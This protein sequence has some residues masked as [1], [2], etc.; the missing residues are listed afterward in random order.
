MSDPIILCRSVRRRGA[1]SEAHGR[2]AL[3]YEARFLRRKRVAL[4]DGGAFHLDLPETTSLNPG[5]AFELSDGRLI[6]VDAADEP[7][8]AVA[9][10]LP[11]LAWHIGNRHAPC[12][13]EE[14]RLLIRRDHVLRDMLL[15][16]GAQVSEIFGPFA[17]EGGAYGHGRT[18]PHDHG[19][20]HADHA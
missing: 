13:I 18:L 16:L 19:H 11:R 6:V 2:V 14:G 20:G 7:L 12:Q 9:G 4:D 5:D 1:W 17:P 8:L 15:R 10:D 3:T